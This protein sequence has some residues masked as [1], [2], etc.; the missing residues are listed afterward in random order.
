MCPNTAEVICVGSFICQAQG[1]HFSII[2]VR[3][4][5]VTNETK[6]SPPA[7]KFDSDMLP[8]S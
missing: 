4:S 7:G 8:A 1:G 2:I 5:I 3:I 6:I